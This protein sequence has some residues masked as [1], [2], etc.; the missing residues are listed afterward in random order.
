MHIEA[1][2]MLADNYAWLLTGD[3]GACAVVD[4][5][6]AEPVLERVRAE[7]L[8]LRWILATH[9]H[10]DHTGGIEALAAACPGIEVMASAEDGAKISGATRVVEDGERIAVAGSEASCLHV[11][12]HT[13]GAVAFHF[14]A[15]DALFTGDTMF[16]SG[17]GRLFEG[18]AEQMHASLEQLAAL[19]ESTRVYCGHEYTQKN[20]EFALSVDPDNR[21]VQQRLAAVSDKRERGE[22]TVPATLAEELATSPFLRVGE[23]VLAALVESTDP[24][25]VFAELRRRRDQF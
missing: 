22:R 21:A 19:P 9:H 2:P 17:C 12:G 20:L 16:L 23:P 5:A 18:T 6:E 11:P 24:A 14:E 25:A 1:L 7:G 10:W 8:R 4:P 13:L 3:D 15:D